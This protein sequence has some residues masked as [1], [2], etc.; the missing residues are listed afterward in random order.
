[1]K[2]NKIWLLLI[3]SFAF[4]L[5]F[6]RLDHLELFGDEL[7][8][9]YQAYSLWKTGRDYM[10]QKLPFYIHSFAEWRAPLLMYATA[11]FVGIFG[12]NEWGVRLPP[13]V[14][15]L[16][17]IFLLYFLVKL[18]TK[19]ERLA[20]ISAFILTVIPW[21]IHYSRTAFEATL[22]LTLMLGGT[23]LFLKKKYLFG[24][25]IF[26]LTLY[27]YNTANIFTPLWIL[28]L[29]ILKKQ[30]LLK[31]KVYYLLLI[32]L[33][34][35]I[36]LSIFSGQGSA[37]FKLISI[38]NN[39]ATIDQIVFKRNTG[40]NPKIERVFY[41]KLTGWGSEFVK[42]Y[43]T[44]FSPQ[45]LFLNGDPNPRHN[46]PEF[47]EFYW[48]LAP[49]L[50]VGIWRLLR[51]KNLAFKHLIFSWL[52]LAPIPSSLTI[53][54]GNQAT[55]L[56][57]MLPPLVILIALAVEKLSFSKLRLLSIYCLLFTVLFFWLHNYFIH[58]PQEQYKYWHYGYKEAMIWLKK[59]EKEHP[60]I[61][62]NNRHEPILLRYLFW[63]E[64]N[65]QW[66]HKNFAGDEGDF[67][68]G[69]VNFARSKIKNDWQENV[70]YL[71]FQKDEVPG[72]W[73]WEKEPPEGVRTLKTVYDPW[74]KPMMYWIIKNNE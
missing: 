65:P 28:I 16:L 37:R 59:Y 50:L 69:K 17:N 56:F 61:I 3:I 48:I 19:N 33:I 30:R 46:P 18:L 34:L 15:G 7:D 24:V 21:H 45:F 64:K 25:I 4:F 36:I 5:R 62:I 32:I 20:L 12:L 74:E 52:L 9:G 6:Y 27:T 41:N 66:L 38:F 29:I 1:M 58:Y 47:G 60:K 14:F 39:P 11:P 26:A 13:V 55:R 44:A 22:L 35:P 51:S 49:F 70:P 53:G 63:T 73:D 71:V 31:L 72:D 2:K 23:I 57:L 42:N 8:V 54:G 67:S 68:L 43:L 10:G 40:L